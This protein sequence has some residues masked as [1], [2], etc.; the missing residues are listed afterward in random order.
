MH[1]YGPQ[2]SSCGMQS[3]S[4][5]ARLAQA[6]PTLTPPANA[7]PRQNTYPTAGT[8]RTP[9]VHARRAHCL[10]MHA[11]SP[12]ARTVPA[13]AAGMAPTTPSPHLPSINAGNSRRKH[14]G[15]SRAPSP[16]HAER[17]RSPHA[18]A[19]ASGATSSSTHPHLSPTYACM[20]F[21]TCTD[22]LCTPIVQLWSVAACLLC[23]MR[24]IGDEI[25]GAY[26]EPRPA[27]CAVGGLA[28]PPC[29][30]GPCTSGVR[31]QVGGY[32]LTCEKVELPNCLNC[33][34]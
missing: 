11:S 16:A 33:E 24:F 28:P 3:S 32:L 4:G 7:S 5:P 21:S 20:H 15:L 13:P 12:L 17:S 14:R 34:C 1:A 10:R 19:P 9:R 8:L 22:T 2:P 27:A 18:Y 29:A 25:P 26:T 6:S 31:T 23:S 30:L